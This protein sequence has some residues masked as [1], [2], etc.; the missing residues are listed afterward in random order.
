MYSM[1]LFLSMLLTCLNAFA[2]GQA[3]LHRANPGGPASESQE[4][5]SSSAIPSRSRA[6]A[7]KGQL[8]NNL[9]SA[10]IS[11]ANQETVRILK[12]CAF[13]DLIRPVD[14]SPRDP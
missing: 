14:S 4:V 5:S 2:P 10:W 7:A 3:M 12:F 9:G 11:R 6:K 8:G 13:V 1:K